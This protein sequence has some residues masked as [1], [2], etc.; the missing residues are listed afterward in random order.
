MFSTF[1]VTSQLGGTCL[2]ASTGLS[3]ALTL[4]VPYTIIGEEIAA[5]QD[6]Q[7]NLAEEELGA[8]P[9][10]Q[11]GA[12]MSLHNVAISLPQIAAAVVCS[13]VFWLARL[14][15]SQDG[16]GIALRIGGLAALGAALLSRR[17]LDDR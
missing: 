16:T 3:W 11:A 1:F 12:I 9:E 5:R 15:A 2:V 7:T 13:G 17:L 10:P 8:S 14:A 6:L 4:W